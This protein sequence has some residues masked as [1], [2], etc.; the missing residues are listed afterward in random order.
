MTIK[1]VKDRIEDLKYD[2]AN[3]LRLQEFCLGHMS[4][5]GD[6]GYIKVYVAL[7]ESADLSETLRSLAS[8][9]IRNIDGEIE[10]LEKIID[11]AIVSID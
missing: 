9:T 7:E 11:S 6:D 1:E 4:K 8:K 3:F 2:R 10:R 5:T